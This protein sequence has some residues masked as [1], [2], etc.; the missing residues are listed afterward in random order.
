MGLGAY[1]TATATHPDS[2]LQ[3][4]SHA[5]PQKC[6]KKRRSNLLQTHSNSNYLDDNFWSGGQDLN[7]RHSGFCM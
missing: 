5:I 7:L 6:Q 3:L 1:H 4:E 2:D